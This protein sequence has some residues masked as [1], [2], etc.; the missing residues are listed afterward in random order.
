[1]RAIVQYVMTPCAEVN[2]VVMIVDASCQVVVVLFVR[3]S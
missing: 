2:V 1:M 3:V